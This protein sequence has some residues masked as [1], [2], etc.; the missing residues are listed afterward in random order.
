MPPLIHGATAPQ[1]LNEILTRYGSIEAFRDHLQ[2]VLDAPTLRLPL[3]SPGGRHRR[4]DAAL[5]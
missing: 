5:P 4:A 1:L 3:P 2:A